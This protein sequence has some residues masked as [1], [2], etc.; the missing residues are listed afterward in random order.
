M[1][2]TCQLFKFQRGAHFPGGM[3]L[4]MVLM[5]VPALPGGTFDM[6]HP[7]VQLLQNRN[8][9]FELGCGCC[10]SLRAVSSCNSSRCRATQPLLITMHGVQ[11]LATDVVRDYKADFNI[12]IRLQT[13]D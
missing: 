10:D 8:H 9:R 12:A 4:L 3:P 13:R 6:V 5:R 7:F 1:W 11:S 2:I